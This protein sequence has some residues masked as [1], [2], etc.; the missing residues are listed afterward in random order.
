MTEARESY[1]AKILYRHEIK[2]RHNELLKR[3][4]EIVRENPTQSICPH[5]HS[6]NYVMK[7]FEAAN[8]NVSQ[9]RGYVLLICE[10]YPQAC[11]LNF[12]DDKND[13]K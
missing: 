7:N 11:E 10:K 4:E 13:I 1:K 3:L 8:F 9:S 2:E 12:E 6:C 5:V